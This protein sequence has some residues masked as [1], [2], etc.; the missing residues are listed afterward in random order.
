MKQ[1]FVQ[2]YPKLMADRDKSILLFDV[3]IHS[4]DTMEPVVIALKEFGFTNLIIGSAK[5]EDMGSAVTPDVTFIDES[6]SLCEPFPQ[7][8]VEKTNDSVH[9]K[10]RVANSQF[11]KEAR[12]AR[13]EIKQMIEE[14]TDKTI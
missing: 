8:V 13:Q 10:R 1:E 3:C 5:S 2:S 6:Q 11:L 12:G 14:G 7:S 4:G 9:T